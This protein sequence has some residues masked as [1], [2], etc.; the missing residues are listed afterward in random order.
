[1]VKCVAFGCKS[2]Y[3]SAANDS[4][5]KDVKITFHTYP[6]NNKE[7]CDKWNR[8]NP[9]QDFLPSKHSKL[10]SL[11]FKPT[12]FI[13][14]RKDSNAARARRKS[15]G[16]LG[17]KLKQRYLKDDAVPSL[18]PNA[19]SYLSSSNSSGVPRET[20]SATSSSRLEREVQR[21]D[22][23]EKSFLASDDISTCT[24]NDIMERL[25]IESAVPEGFMTSLTDGV[26]LLYLLQISNDCIPSVKSCIAVK[27]DLS[28]VASQYADLFKG[29]VQRMSQLLNL[30]ARIKSW[31]EGTENRSLKFNIQMAISCLEIGMDN[32]EDI[33]SEEYKKL[34]FTVEQLKL[35]TKQKYGRHYSPQ[36]TIFAFMIHAASAAAYDVLL[37]EKLLCIPSTSTL[38]KV[39]KRLDGT[40]GLD[41]SAYLKLRA[42]KLNQFE[43]TVILII[44]EIYIAKRVEYSGGEVQGLTP[45]GSV[46][47]TLLCF[48]VKSLAS[49]YKD[50][51]AIY[52]ICKLTAAKQFEC[53]Q[54]VAALLRTV[55]LNVVAISVDNATTNRKFF[56]D[57]LCNGTLQTHVVDPITGQPIYLIFDPVH[58]IKNVYNNFQS[59]KIFHCP[60]MER[61]LPDGCSAYFKDIVDLFDHEASMSLKKAHRLSPATLHP[62]SIEKTS[63]KLATSVFCE[64]TR[65][66]LCYYAVNEGKNWAGTADFIT[67]M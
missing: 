64:S 17:D 59:R 65:D 50:I 37:D 44:D 57:C 36:L 6:I 11:H 29:Q 18:F 43:Q 32:L 33:D 47:T 15:H 55:S 3:K 12:D 8:A 21:F 26:L 1:M 41:N 66:A 54:E 28:V 61:N 7:L 4:Q 42:S 48:V 14:E 67:L 51:V 53:Y 38:R 62:K 22:E 58:D 56:V 19:P 63:V 24:T 45:D 10:C 60:P 35:L 9:R 40:N 20:V 30:M 34:N 5:C 49:R 46:A 52:P 23:L 39:T 2:G 16:V 13:E 31:S 25:D 27:S